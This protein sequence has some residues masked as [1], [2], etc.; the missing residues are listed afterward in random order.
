MSARRA[1]ILGIGMVSS[2]GLSA[3]STAAAVRAD[4]NRFQAS[5]I[6][7]RRGEP[8]IMALVATEDLPPLAPEVLRAG[9]MS[10]REER[11]LKLGGVALRACAGAL[12]GSSSIPLLLASP[13]RHPGTSVGPP[14]PTFLELLA[15]QAAVPLDRTASRL[16]PHGR[17]GALL[18]LQ[19]GIDALAEGTH[20]FLVIGGADTHLD[21]ALLDALDAED[22]LRAEGVCDGFTPGEGAAFLLLARP[23]A[24]PRPGRTR[25]ASIAAV[26][27][28]DEP[29]HRDS[30]EPYRGEGLDLALRRL[31]AAFAAATPV[32]TVYSGLNGESFSAKEWGVA[33][34]RHRQRFAEGITHAHP[35]DCLGDT[36][37]ALAPML[38]GLAALGIRS[39]YL[40]HP[41]L[42]W[43]SSDRALRGAALVTKADVH[44]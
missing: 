24:R 11:M 30:T 19:H 5:E 27:T 20:E 36:G 13:E 2:V 23:D 1:D 16:F 3:Q 38:L 21:G 29:G 17:A 26:A 44:Q 42:V 33:A 14:G 34:L 39:R 6:L 43:C 22:R 12:P 4:L 37:A 25:I 9:E 35:A 32:R 31:F 8:V 41:C 40:E 7:D 10:T 28:A 15:A 18:A